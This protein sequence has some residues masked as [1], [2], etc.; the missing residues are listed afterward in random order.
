MSLINNEQPQHIEFIFYSGEGPNLCAGTLLLRI[1]DTE[2]C[3]RGDNDMTDKNSEN[4]A[5][6]SF[7]RSGGDCGYDF[8]GTPGSTEGEWI[9]DVL[10]LPEHLRKYAAEIDEVFNKNVEWGCCGGCV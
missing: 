5:Y 4:G 6:K 3:F 7:W 10:M 2:Y 9:I 8:E 1:D